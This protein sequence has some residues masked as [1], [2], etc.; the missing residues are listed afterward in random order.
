MSPT[1]NGDGGVRWSDY[2]GEYDLLAEHNPHYQALLHSVRGWVERAALPPGSTVIDLGG[3]T[4][5]FSLCV[6]QARPDYRVV[7]MD[8]DGESLRHAQKKCDFL[9]LSNLDLHHRDMADLTWLGSVADGPRLFLCIHALYLAGAPD[10]PDTPR[11]VL[12]ALRRT[13][14]PGD[15]LLISDVGRPIPVLR[16]GSA[17]AWRMG[18]QQGL[19]PL[20][21]AWRRTRHA[22]AANRAIVRMQRRGQCLT[23]DLA[24]FLDL[25]QHAGLPS[26]WI[27]DA[28]ETW[29]GGIDSSV[30]LRRPPV[31]AG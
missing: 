2:A 20:L 30:L 7:L 22:R 26:E 8:T 17:M 9:G 1:G 31:N 12:R 13:M 3:G 6:A 27:V 11:E 15:W 23:H 5:N 19:S 16:W 21:G 24:G 10:T 4:G 14:C 25:L 18:R 29:F 28:S